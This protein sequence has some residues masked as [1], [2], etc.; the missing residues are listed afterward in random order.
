M[1][2][3]PEMPHQPQNDDYR[4]ISRRS[5]RWSPCEVLPQRFPDLPEHPEGQG[6][7]ASIAF[8]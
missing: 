6:R 3:A 7:K 5:R 8:L 2:K 4:T 1:R